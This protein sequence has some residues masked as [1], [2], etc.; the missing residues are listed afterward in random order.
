MR[1]AK[2][3]MCWRGFT[4]SVLEQLRALQRGEKILFHPGK[5]FLSNGIARNEHQFDRLGK[6]VLVQAEGF[7]EQAPGAAASWR[8][9]DFFAGDDAEPGRG[10]IG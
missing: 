3:K 7:A 2:I 4:I 10:A 1:T 6:F 5:I 8:I 9:A